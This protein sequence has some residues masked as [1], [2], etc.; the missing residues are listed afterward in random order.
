MCLVFGQTSVTLS[1]SIAR[2]LVRTLVNIVAACML[3]QGLPLSQHADSI[4]VLWKLRQMCLLVFE[5]LGFG[6]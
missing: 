3:G 2:D 4:T 5:A 1:S 6:G